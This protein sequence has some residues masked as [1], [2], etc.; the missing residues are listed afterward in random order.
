MAEGAGERAQT[1]S[2]G[3]GSAVRDGGH[4]NEEGGVA[5]EL[6]PGL[7]TA[8][9][10]QV[11][12]L[13]R[14]YGTN[15]LDKFQ[16]VEGVATDLAA[17]HSFLSAPENHTVTHEGVDMSIQCARAFLSVQARDAFSLRIQMHWHWG[18]GSLWYWSA[19]ARD[20]EISLPISGALG[21]G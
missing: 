5:E 7:S 16:N 11:I 3:E 19:V 8:V 21:A 18:N 13:R 10:L 6:D 17:V 14:L 9:K 2:T 20:L 1:S 4:D 15:S 12:F